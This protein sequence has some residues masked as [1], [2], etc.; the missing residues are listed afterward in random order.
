MLAYG[1]YKL[2]FRP[3]MFLCSTTEK[4]KVND[5]IMGHVFVGDA[6]VHEDGP[7]HVHTTLGIPFN[8]L[9]NFIQSR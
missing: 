5:I 1:K 7:A 8:L 6:V 3:S 2:Y 4:N 9:T